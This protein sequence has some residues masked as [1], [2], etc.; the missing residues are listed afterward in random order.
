MP[1]Y[2]SRAEALVYFR[3]RELSSWG[4]LSWHSGSPTTEA[5]LPVGHHACLRHRRRR[6]HRQLAGRSPARGRPRRRRP[7][8]TSPPASASSSTRRSASS[9]LHAGRRRHARSAGADRGHGAGATSCSTSPPTPTS[10]SAPSI[11]A[12]ISS[13]TPSPR[14]TCSRRCAPT[15]SSGSRSRRPAR[16]TARR[17]LPDAGRRAVPGADLALRR[18]EARRRRADRG[19]LRR[20]SASRAASSA[21][22]RSSASATRTATSST[23]IKSLRDDPTRL[24]VLGNGKQRKSYLYVQDCLD[25]MLAGDRDDARQASRSSTSAPTS[26]AR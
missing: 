12:G 7:T 14:S 16:S 1:W 17:S 11:R 19:L 26:T 4:R 2:G 8:T 9:P 20:A 25:A 23:S 5:I 10:A 15:A 24:R 21:S 18:L 22:S 6:L 13:R 3:G